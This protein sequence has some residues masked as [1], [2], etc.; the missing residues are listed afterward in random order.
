MN[1]EMCMSV[2]TL[3]VVVVTSPNTGP[4]IICTPV[5]RPV[6]H[7]IT[8][9]F[10][11]RMLINVSYRGTS[12]NNSLIHSVIYSPGLQVIFL[13]QMMTVSSWHN[14]AS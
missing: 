11:M 8:Q 13:E 6:R 3:M 2:G 14:F 1:E 9:E 10:V 4:M 5:H 12:S 7:D